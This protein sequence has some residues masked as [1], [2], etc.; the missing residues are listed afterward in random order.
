MKR[1][2]KR[3][4]KPFTI[5]QKI[6]LEELF[7]KNELQNN[8]NNLSDQFNVKKRKIEDWLYDRKRN[9]IS[10][11]IDKLELQLI[12]EY[13]T[14]NIICYKEESHFIETNETF[15]M[16]YTTRQLNNIEND[17]VVNESPNNYIYQDLID[18]LKVQIYVNPLMTDE[19]TNDWK[20]YLA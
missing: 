4:R 18:V 7:L 13:N 5:E 15:Q 16:G 20:K 9:R 14:K 6:I 19:N 12:K 3:V 10:H 11:T 17:Y 8:I 1:I 2:K